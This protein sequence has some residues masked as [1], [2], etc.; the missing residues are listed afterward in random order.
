MMVMCSFLTAH[1]KEMMYRTFFTTGLEMM[2][3]LEKKVR[4]SQSVIT[5][6]SMRRRAKLRLDSHKITR[7]L[8]QNSGKS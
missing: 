6:N 4:A 2:P 5:S 3:I 7:L 8:M 1:K